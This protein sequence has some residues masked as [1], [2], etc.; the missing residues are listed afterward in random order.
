[1][2]PGAVEAIHIAEEAAG[3]VRPVESAMLRRGAGID[4]DRYGRREGT[5]SD[6]PLDHELTLVEA[7]VLESLA[8][9]HGVTL[10]PGESR[11]N[12]TTRGIA[13]N[14][15]V[16]KRFRIGGVLCEGTRLCEPCAHLERLTGIGGLARVMA[17]RGGLRA[18]V[19]EDGPIRVGD[20]VTVEES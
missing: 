6:R 13:L 19:L 18:L 12:L 3:P 7:E 14:P 4:G 11:R 10:A 15:L 1:M 9:E 5:F 2:T 17:G 16:G 8:A 20:P